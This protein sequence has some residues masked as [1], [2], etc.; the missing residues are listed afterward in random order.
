MNKIKVLLV[1]PNEEPKQV[2]IENTE[3]TIEKVVGG[4]L[5]YIKLESNIMLICNKNAKKQDLEFNR[6]IKNDVIAGTFI[7]TGYNK[8]AITSLKDID[9]E[10]R[11]FKLKNDEGMIK[12]FRDNLYV[13]SNLLDPKLDF[14]N[15][16]FTRGFITLDDIDIES[17][18][19]S[20]KWNTELK[21]ESIERLKML[22]L[23]DYAFALENSDT[24][25]ISYIDKNVIHEPTEA[26]QTIIENLQYNK[27]IMVYHIIRINDN[28][29][30]YLFVSRNKDEWQ[31]ERIAL[32]EG[33]ADAICLKPSKRVIGIEVTNSI[34]TKIV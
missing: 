2:E 29:S 23:G 24:I 5:E 31:S 12:F 34:I 19:D 14:R 13:S 18:E 25:F 15:I 8:G 9:K 4:K 22:N 6:V 10:M 7:V 32:K 20:Q 17:I 21:Q 28:V 30:Y 33:F 26:E 16:G 1:E 27:K 3:D 11:Y